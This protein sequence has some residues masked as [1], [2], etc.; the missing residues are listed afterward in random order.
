MQ[1]PPPILAITKPIILGLVI[2]LLTFTNSKPA[3]AET[4]TVQ[5]ILASAELKLFGY[6]VFLNNEGFRD[7][8][9]EN[10]V[11]AIIAELKQFQPKELNKFLHH[12]EDFL[13]YADKVDIKLEL[14]EITEKERE[15]GYLK[16]FYLTYKYNDLYHQ[17]SIS[18]AMDAILLRVKTEHPEMHLFYYS[19]SAFNPLFIELAYPSNNNIIPLIQFFLDNG[20][21]INMRN[22]KFDQ[23]IFYAVSTLEIAQF[24]L[25]NGADPN[26]LSNGNATPLMSAISGEDSNELIKFLIDLG[27]DLHAKSSFYGT[28]LDTAKEKVKY[29]EK[30]IWKLDNSSDTPLGYQLLPARLEKAEEVVRI[31]E[32]A[33]EAEANKP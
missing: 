5:E 12:T 24:L 3:S 7:I 28:A 29:L 33:L 25:A 11:Q 21:D 30:S 22:P 8:L 6:Y 18:P 20:V 26:I 14:I 2:C 16:H 15:Y 19:D 17:F 9:T 13:I 4:K 10:D 27:V 31:I 32:Q 23:A 1:L